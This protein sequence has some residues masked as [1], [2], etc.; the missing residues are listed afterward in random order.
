MSYYTQ[1]GP[2]G[3]IFSTYDGRGEISR[4]ALVGLGVGTVASYG[5]RGDDLT[6][7]ELDQRVVDIAEN[8]TYFTYLQDTPATVHMVVGD[9]RLELAKAPPASY[10]L[11]VLDAFSSDAIPVHLLT[12]EAFAMY[13]AK[14]V[15]GGLLVV[16]ITNG[17]LD[18]E[19]VVASVAAATGLQART[20]FDPLW[21]KASGRAAS[22]WVV[23]AEDPGRLAALPAQRGWRSLRTRAG[24]TWTDDYSNIVSIL[25]LG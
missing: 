6:I 20:R 5:R 15:P 8:P 21:D 11:I 18:L 12:T 25:K 3:D 23:L 7:Y 17:H 2:L 14:L 16:H 10:Q 24:T 1:D 13:R 19:P 4:F 22:Q 9:G